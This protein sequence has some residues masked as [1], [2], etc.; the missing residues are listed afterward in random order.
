MNLCY[1]K[2]C[3]QPLKEE[4]T[5]CPNCGQAVSATS[6]AHHLKCGTILKE[7]YLVGMALGEGGFGITYIGRDLTLDMR[8]AIKEY[9]PNGCANRSHNFSNEVTMTQGGHGIDYEKDMRRFLSEARILARFS[10]EPGVVCVRDYFQ[11]NGTAYIVMEY[12]DGVTLKNYIAKFGPIPADTFIP[13]I[14]PILQVLGDIHKQG[15]IHRDISPDNIMMLKSGRLKLLDFGAAREVTGDKSLSVVL[16]PGYAPEEQYRSKGKQG[17]WTDVYAM[18][19]TIYKC[20]TGVTPDESMQRVFEDELKPPSALG[21]SIPASQE[22]ALMQGLSVKS[23]D[24]IQTIDALRKAFL[25]EGPDDIKSIHIHRTDSQVEEK[26]DERDK[27][28]KYQPKSDKTIA[29]TGLGEVTIQQDHTKVTHTNTGEDAVDEEKTVYQPIDNTSGN[30]ND[31]ATSGTSKVQPEIKD[32]PNIDSAASETDTEQEYPIKEKPIMV[33]GVTGK[34]IKPIYLGIGAAVLA[35][36]VA[37]IILIASVGKTPEANIQDKLPTEREM[38]SDCS[39][40]LKNG[41]INGGVLDLQVQNENL[42]EKFKTLTIT[43]DV[44]VSENGSTNH[45]TVKLC[46]EYENETWELSELSKTE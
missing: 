37:V 20:I 41:G 15:L 18:C 5:V 6:P 12:L 24:R 19:A 31:D 17:S 25:P 27:K 43:C 34:K 21:V 30:P 14:D 40:V 46:Y 33:E 1:C 29:D 45:Y 8:I 38:A 26:V 42:N 7:K 39:T 10:N 3:M 22:T 11:E 44:T 36:I 9:Y 32:S 2:S 4:E 16:K 23:S 13:M 35:I 28:T